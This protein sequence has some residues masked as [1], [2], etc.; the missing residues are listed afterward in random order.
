MKISG[1]WNGHDCSYCILKDGEPVV[2]NEYERFLR[3]KEPQGDAFNF[4]KE[5]YSDYKD[6]KYFATCHPLSKTTR[7]KETFEEM[8]QIA[9]KNNGCFRDEIFKKID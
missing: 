8:Q 1:F 3:E 4:L 2:H 6:I 5:N 9:N 7:F